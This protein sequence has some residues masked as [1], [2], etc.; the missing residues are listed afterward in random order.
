VRPDVKTLVVSVHN[1]KKHAQ[2]KGGFLKSMNTYCKVMKII[3]SISLAALLVFL[4]ACGSS[5]G[6]TSVNSNNNSKPADDSKPIK[7]GALMTFSGPFSSFG[8][9]LKKGMELYFE[10]NNYMIG[11][12]KVEIIYEDDENNPQVALRK[13]HK[14]VDQD[15]V[16]L[17]MGIATSTILYAIRDEVDNG[18]IPLIVANAAGNDVSWD[19]KSEYIY[20][21]SYSNWQMGYAA[22]PY[23]VKNLGKKAYVISY[24]NPAGYEQAE[25]FKI[26]FE[27]GGG[28]VLKIEYPKPGTSDFAN[29][30][31]QIAAAKPD[32]VYHISAGV[33]GV[34]F[35]LQFKEFGLKDK[36]KLMV[37]TPSNLANTPELVD[38]LNGTYLRFDY[39]DTAD[40]EANKKFLEA[41]KK[42]Y[43][44]AELGFEPYGYES[45]LLADAAIKK[46]GSVK[47]EDLIKAL[48]NISIDGVRG[49]V[50]MDPKTHNPIIDYY[51][52]RYDAKDGKLVKNYIDT[53]KEVTMPEKNPNK[54]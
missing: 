2:I 31:T 42:K 35:A 45:A 40:N 43:N 33:D 32:V 13:Y 25:A 28:Q 21:S 22:G 51:I 18:K 1:S 9:G 36:I 8:D 15:K 38:A 5:G 16:D 49:K 41:F 17:L 24:D 12:R 37:T 4:T 34:R 27:E 50:T 29:Y 14:L 11:N 54:K 44:N 26:A 10:Q 46:A 7:I 52:V 30:M 23:A 53:I 6:N 48:K 19:K 20:R 3:I 47:S 39:K